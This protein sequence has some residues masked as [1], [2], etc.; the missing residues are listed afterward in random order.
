MHIEDVKSITVIIMVPLLHCLQCSCHEYTQV[1]VRVYDV[2]RAALHLYIA[3]G[4]VIIGR[5]RSLCPCIRLA[6]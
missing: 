4:V 3:R 1:F 2:T 6:N 5:L